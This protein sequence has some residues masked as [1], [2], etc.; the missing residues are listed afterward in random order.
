[1]EWL[2]DILSEFE[3]RSNL[4]DYSIESTEEHQGIWRTPFDA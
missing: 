4:H 2:F 1:M 3:K